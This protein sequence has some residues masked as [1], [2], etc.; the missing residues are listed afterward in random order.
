MEAWRTSKEIQVEVEVQIKS[1]SGLSR[2]SEEVH[3]KI[4][5]LVAYGL[6]FGRFL[7]VHKLKNK[8]LPMALVSS[9]NSSGV[10]GNHQNKF[11]SR[12]CLGAAPLYF[13]L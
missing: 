4:V 11:T 12:I 10:V 6:G 5:A 7:Y 13:G 2:S 9:P 1:T 8:T 3:G